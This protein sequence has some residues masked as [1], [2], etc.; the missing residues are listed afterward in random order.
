M[1]IKT[2][3]DISKAI[4]DFRCIHCSGVSGLLTPESKLINFNLVNVYQ[5]WNNFL[6]KKDL[7]FSR[8]LNIY[9][10]DL[11][12]TYALKEAILSL[13]RLD[14]EKWKYKQ[15]M[16]DWQKMNLLFKSHEA[17][18]HLVNLTVLLRINYERLILCL[19]ELFQCSE[20]K[21]FEAKRKAIIKKMNK[22]KIDKNLIDLIESIDIS[23]I[24]EYR[25]KIIHQSGL[26]FQ[27]FFPSPSAKNNLDF[28]K[29]LGEIRDEIVKFYVIIQKFISY[30]VKGEIYDSDKRP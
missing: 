13:N 30:S 17:V 14:A 2:I 4:S 25:E 1:E 29:F 23:K 26:Y 27:E 5:N 19:Q 7:S 28:D 8:F 6:G 3:E 16:K 20:G 10:N 21:K 22:E 11:L 24:K 9:H 15:P 12:L 18:Y